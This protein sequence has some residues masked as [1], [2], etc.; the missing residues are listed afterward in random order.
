MP[1]ISTPFS[2]RMFYRKMGSGPAI[3]LIH[4]FPE[5][6]GLWRK[7]QDKLAQNYTLIIPDLPGSGNSSLENKV[8]LSQMAEGINGILETEG[9]ESSIIAG[10]SMG[11]YV[12]FAYAALFPESVAGL[13]LVHSSP[14]A[15]DEERKEIRKKAIEIVKNGGKDLF[16]RQLVTGLFGN[17]FKLSEPKIVE[18]QIAVACT[19]EVTGLINFYEAMMDRPDRTNVLETA[20]FPIHWIVGGQDN[21]I[22]LKKSLGNLYK[23][24]INFVTFNPDCGHMGM[25]EMPDRVIKEL[26]EFSA[27]SFSHQ[28]SQLAS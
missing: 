14:A 2:S 25:L 26:S 4:G 11:G 18:D 13:C 22:P 19:M 7:I 23:A 9:I 27:Y 12:A 24:Q 16:L 6:G 10:H 3:V 20:Q 8:S 17:D 15:D 5:S 1:E 28:K 21:V